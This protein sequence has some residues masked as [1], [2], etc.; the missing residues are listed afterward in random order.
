MIMLNS[1]SSFVNAQDP[2]SNVT[3]LIQYW[4]YP[5]EQHY[6]T[7]TDGFI[8]SVQRIPY[9]RSSLSRQIPK[10]KKKVV[11]LQHGFLDCSATWVNNLPYQ[12]LGYIL[13]DAGFDVWLGNARGNEYSN[14]NIYHSKHDKQFWNFSWDEISILNEEMAIYDLTAMVDYALKVSG[15]PKLAYVGHSQGTT[16]GFECFS[17]NA[18]SNTKYPACPKD[19]TNKISIFIA[20]APVTYLEHVNSPMMEALAKLHVD[21]I[22]EFLGVGDFLPT[23][24]QLEKWIPGICSNSILQKAVCMNVYC[25]MSG[26]DGLE[27]KANSSRLPLYMDRL[28]AGTSTMNAGH[29][30]QLVRSKKFQMFDY[31]FGNYDHY[32]QVSAPQIELSNLHVDIAIYHGGLDI[33]ADYNDVKK[34][35]SKLPKERLKNVMF[36][37]DF[38]HIDLVWG[39]NN[40]QL[41]FNDIVKRVSDSFN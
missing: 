15:Q 37:S 22:L 12:S 40:Y 30:A 27:N 35:L 41:F 26:C 11:F 5:V 16:M 8:L 6:V 18:D 24:Q 2:K 10:D 17:S 34:L 36:F 9:G 20:I 14:R 39:I 31:H 21:E 4:G 25:I 19:F 32:H 29:W 33:L 1:S 13:A 28:P 38:G 3:Q 23:T 7:T